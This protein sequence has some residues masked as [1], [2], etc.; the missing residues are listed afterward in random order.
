[1]RP[2][3]VRFRSASPAHPW[4]NAY[5]ERLN[6]SIRRAC[7]ERM[8]I[9]IE[10]HLGRVLKEHSLEMGLSE[11]SPT[12][13]VYEGDVIAIPHVRGLHHHYEKRVA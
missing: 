4:Q 3:R 10:D 6:G 8:I 11:G 12:Q 1:M 13:A 5:P 7:L 9:S 2:R